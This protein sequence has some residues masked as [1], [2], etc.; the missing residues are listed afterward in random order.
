[1]RTL[2]LVGSVLLCVPSWAR[3]R[4]PNGAPKQ[5]V[6]S[7]AVVDDEPIPHEVQAPASKTTDVLDTGKR[8]EIEISAP[9]VKAV[10]S[11]PGAM[12]DRGAGDDPAKLRAAQDVRVSGVHIDELAER[13]M[14]RYRR[15]VETCTGPTNIKAPVPAG[16]I[17]L[18]ITVAQK[19]VT[20]IALKAE[21]R[22][23]LDAG[24]EKRVST[25]FAE[26]SKRWSFSLPDASF[27]HTVE[28]Q[29]GSPVSSR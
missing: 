17:S 21:P 2:V 26:A 8:R 1:M 10:G 29:K 25:C 11:T 5:V 18:A 4:R 27:S 3:E 7:V 13:Q 14:R 12:I 20:G 6:K 22:N 19:K 23:N 9:S 16:T 24:D 15:D 28:V